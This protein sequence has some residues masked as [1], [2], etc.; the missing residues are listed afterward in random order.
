MQWLGSDLSPLPF[1]VM[2]RTLPLIHC[3]MSIVFEELIHDW[4]FVINSKQCQEKK[5]PGEEM[6]K[7]VEYDDWL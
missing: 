5:K 2:T 4:A 1:G 3:I 7:R 6:D